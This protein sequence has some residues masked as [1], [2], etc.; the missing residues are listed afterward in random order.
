MKAMDEANRIKTLK[1]YNL[2]DSAAEDAFDQLTNLAANVCGTSMSLVSLVD[3]DRQWFKSRV[4]VSLSETPRNI[5]FCSETIKNRE[6]MIVP[7]ALSDS[8]F[9]NNP[10]VLDEPNIRFYAGVPL[11]VSNGETLGTLCV[12]DSR[13][14]ELSDTQLLSLI[15]IANS[16]R[17][18][19]ELR[20]KAE[21]LEKMEQ[22]LPICSWCQA[23]RREDETWQPLDEYLS[24]QSKVTHGICP[25]CLEKIEK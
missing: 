10:L 17:N 18:L 1:M 5:A 11:S 20:H 21:L 24:E 23:V 19:I 3:L 12:L 14:R 2:L 8:R 16:V 9:S 15:A 6:P 22:L 25:D 4:G 7:D 13:P